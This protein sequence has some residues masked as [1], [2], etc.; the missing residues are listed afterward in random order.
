VR[1][2]AAATGPPTPAGPNSYGSR[3]L[4]LGTGNR[5]R[6]EGEPAIRRTR[7]AASRE[8]LADNIAQGL[9]P[10]FQEEARLGLPAGPVLENFQRTF[11]QCWL[12]RPGTHLS[13]LNVNRACLGD[14]FEANGRPRARRAN[15]RC[16]APQSRA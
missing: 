4:G 7:D 5:L 10:D 12:K 9:L 3:C 15:Q 16:W 8:E 11:G 6:T 2:L 14:Q 1:I 13:G